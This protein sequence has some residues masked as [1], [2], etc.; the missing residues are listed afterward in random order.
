MCW[1]LTNQYKGKSF[2]G[3]PF[4]ISVSFPSFFHS[5]GCL[6]LI[7]LTRTCHQD[8]WAWDFSKTN[9]TWVVFL[10]IA[11]GFQCTRFAH[12]NFRSVFCFVFLPN[13]HTL[14]F[15]V[16][17]RV[18][19]NYKP[20]SKQIRPLS[21]SVSHMELVPVQYGQGCS[22]LDGPAGFTKK[23]KKKQ[24]LGKL[25]QVS[26]IRILLLR[27]KWCHFPSASQPKRKPVVAEVVQSKS[28]ALV[29][30]GRTLWATSQYHCRSRSHF[31]IIMMHY[32]P[33][34]KTLP[35]TDGLSCF[36]LYLY[37]QDQDILFRVNLGATLEAGSELT[38]SAEKD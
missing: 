26:V 29:R 2:A 13:T 16:R 33:D 14:V 34:S 10:L 30:G 38:G 3:I 5:A 12:L 23:K 15:S 37:W 11:S 27:D 7:P 28:A 32:F 36:L 21:L 17:T 25:L 24:L 22:S 31:T 8:N 20:L 19:L 6:Q 1:P 18:I 35:F 9:D 4:F